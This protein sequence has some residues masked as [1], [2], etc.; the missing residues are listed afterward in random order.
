MVY[1]VHIFVIALTMAIIVRVFVSLYI[2]LPLKCLNFLRT[3]TRF[4]FDHDITPGIRPAF[5][6]KVCVQE[7]LCSAVL[8][9]RN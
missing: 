8:K 4:G 2:M 9:T 7:I 3:R 6:P 1:R 5:Y